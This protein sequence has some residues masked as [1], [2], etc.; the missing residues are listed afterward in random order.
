MSFVTKRKRPAKLRKS[1][2]WPKI[3]APPKKRKTNKDTPKESKSLR[4]KAPEKRPRYR[5]PAMV[6]RPFQRDGVDFLKKH[7]HRVLLADAPGCGKAQPVDAHVLTPSG[8]RT[9]GSLSGGDTVIDPDGG[10]ATVRGVFPQ[11]EK[12]VY[13]VTTRDGS[14]AECCAEHLWTVQTPDDRRRQK[15]R[16]L[17]LSALISAGCRKGAE[18]PRSRHRW[19]LP[20]AAPAV[21]EPLDTPLPLDPYL[22]GVLLGDGGFTENTPTLSNGDQWILSQVH[23]RLPPGV[24]LNTHG[25]SGV[26]HRLSGVGSRSAQNPLTTCLRSLGLMGRLSAQKHIPPAYLKA[27]VAER[28][29]LLAGLLDTDGSPA[30]SSVE[31]STSSPHMKEAVV[32]LVGSLGGYAKATERVPVYTYKGEKRE[33][34]VSHRVHLHM[35]EN[36]FCL[37]RKAAKWTATTMARP[38]VSIEPTR[39]VECVC[40][41]VDSARSLY[42]TDGFLVT[43]NTPQILVAIKENAQKLCPALVVVPSSVVENWRNEA[44]RWIPGVRVALANRLDK[45]LV[46]DAHI[47]VTTWD[48]LAMRSGEFASHGFQF[49]VCDEAHYA[50]NP[51]AQRTQGLQT[52]AASVPH[53]TLLTGTPLVN[54]ADE[55]D[56]LKSLID[57]HNEPPMLRRLLEDVAPDI[58]PK[59]RVILY[60]AIPDEI[61]QEYNE[62]VEV[63]EQWL[64]EYL[65]NVLENLTS[66]DTATA[67]AMGAESLSKLSY[68]RRILGRGK[69]PA[70]AAWALNMVKQ[71]G[72]KVVIFGQYTDV[73]D[74][75]GQALSKLGL[76]YVRL[77]G[78]STHEQRQASVEAF[79]RGE[80][81]VFV[82]SQA[83]RE[84]ITLTK[85]ANLLFLE[86]WWTPAAEEQAED[87]VRRITQTRTTT[88]WYL[89]AEDSLDDRITEIVEA[90]RI[91]VSQHIGTATIETSAMAEV[92]DVWQRIKELK[93]GVPLVSVNPK[94]DLNLPPLPE[95]KYV[96]SVIFE[97]QEWPIDTLQRHLRK[98]RYRT[99]KINRKGTLVQI[100]C[101]AISSFRV[102]TLRKRQLA[103]GIW[104]EIGQPE[105]K[106]SLRMQSVRAERKRKGLK[107]LTDRRVVRTSGRGK[108][109]ALKLG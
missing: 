92:L 16:T 3:K 33:G 80:I 47:T 102:G 77:D 37:P 15:T 14:S 60:A 8:W 87:R 5:G 34:Q 29:A 73:L 59:R 12:Q 99:R 22:L 86:R 109:K 72:E 10:H 101:R 44:E 52:V 56:V 103:P 82:G 84:G 90:K 23:G 78:S 85:G 13:R 66:V 71:R 95:A 30:R 6:L 46:A 106:A 19:F 100:Q 1:K 38:I 63:Y 61:R 39:T 55:L 97:S 62:V 18:G 54:S 70:A 11:G 96:F 94:A 24:V 53:T 105:T 81:D 35:P 93:D 4:L 83:A 91:L 40:I 76:T 79:Q 2:G 89:H 28:K 88:I 51:D 107:R 58:P 48:L 36:P 42:V 68:L 64:Q 32:F 108:K 98:N 26:D 75:L 45:P 43:H 57:R 49:L 7:N 25:D 104:L 74:L 17:P 20:T 69:V 65:P 9:I 21:F 67:R 31:Y 27:S 50:K 41:A